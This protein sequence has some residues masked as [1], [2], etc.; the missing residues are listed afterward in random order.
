[1]KMN[2]KPHADRLSR[3]RAGFSLVEVVLA[4]GIAASTV[5]MLVSMLP[6]GMDQM[7][8]SA[9]QMATARILRWVAQDLQMRNFDEWASK[10]QTVEYK[11]DAGGDPVPGRDGNDLESI[12][13]VRV[14]P[15]AAT[16]ASGVELP[17]DASN[18]YL[19]QVSVS[20]SD[21]PGRDPFSDAKKVWKRTV[22]VVRMEKSSTTP[23]T[24]ASSSSDSGPVS[25]S[26]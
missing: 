12:Y 20:I 17:G 15:D 3:Y 8:N 1:M 11:F 26:L 5:M 14:L 19:R 9:N 10:S 16:A 25:A 6:T 22:T 23:T 24:A 13:T 21:R 2:A 18:Q 7:R 4:V